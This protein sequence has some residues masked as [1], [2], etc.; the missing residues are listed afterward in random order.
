[1][2]L[3]QPVNREK[4]KCRGTCAFLPQMAIP[5]LPSRI[6]FSVEPFSTKIDSLTA[7]VMDPTSSKAKELKER[8]ANVI[9]HSPG[10]EKTMTK[11]LKDT[12]YDTICLIPPA[13]KD[14]HDIS[15]EL[16]TAAK[17]SG[18]S[19]VLLISSVGCDYADPKK[20]PHL[21]EFIELENLTLASKGDASTPLGHSPC[22]IR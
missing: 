13:H 12:G 18:I 19:N 15:V 10:R 1:M 21:R 8:G 11:T 22:V 6:Y 5:A 14:K 16:I 2:R 20:Q 17:R 4:E 7:L 9:K 3:Y